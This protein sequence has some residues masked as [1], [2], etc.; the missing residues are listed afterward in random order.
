MY[1]MSIR[2]FDLSTILTPKACKEYEEQDIT[3]NI[4]IFRLGITLHRQSLINPD[5]K[6]LARLYSSLEKRGAALINTPEG[7]IQT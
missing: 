5:N 6:D 3:K 2:D 4:A 1:L 7:L